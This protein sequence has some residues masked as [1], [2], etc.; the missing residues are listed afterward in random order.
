MGN[1]R[2]STVDIVYY[3]D[4][5]ARKPK[6]TDWIKIRDDYDVFRDI[7][8]NGFNPREIGVLISGT[9]VNKREQV[10][11]A[12]IDP[13]I[14]PEDP[15]S[16]LG[17][18]FA[19]NR[20][21]EVYFPN[22]ITDEGKKWANENLF[23]GTGK[24]DNGGKWKN[25][26]QDEHSVTEFLPL[27]KEPAKKFTNPDTIRAYYPGTV[28]TLFEVGNSIYQTADKVMSECTNKYT[29]SS[30][31]LTKTGARLTIEN[32]AEG[33]TMNASVYYHTNI[34]NYTAHRDRIVANCTDKIFQGVSPTNP[35]YGNNCIGNEYNFYLAW[36]LK[37]NKNRY[38][39]AGAYVAISK[40]HI[41]LEYMNADKAIV[42]EKI[43]KNEAVQ[44]FGVRRKKG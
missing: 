21:N 43:Y 31:C 25:K 18:T 4:F 14:P 7:E 17:G 8:G 37:T 44:M 2:D 38:V 34:G 26:A 30:H 13:K 3:A 36:D 11:I 39:G 22:W 27:P 15:R 24:G 33:I 9:N 42:T 35:Q 20:D 19:G 1:Q 41:I 29:E 23:Q 12:V 5:K 16:T 40:V 10:K 28:G 32:I 6:A